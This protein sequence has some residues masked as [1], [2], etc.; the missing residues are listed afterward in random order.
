MTQRI[1]VVGGPWPTRIG[2]GGFMVEP[3]PVEALIYPFN[4]LGRGEVVIKLDADPIWGP[5][6]GDKRWTCVIDRADVRFL[7]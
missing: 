6:G 3:D 1:V 4:G 2:S 7:P 5:L